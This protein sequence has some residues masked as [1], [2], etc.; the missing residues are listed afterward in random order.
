MEGSQ[1]KITLDESVVKWTWS[2]YAP[3]GVSDMY[4]HLSD[5][6]KI[7]KLA[8]QAPKRSKAVMQIECEASEAIQCRCAKADE[9]KCSSGQRGQ[10]GGG[11]LVYKLKIGV[12]QWSAHLESDRRKRSG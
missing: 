4:V 7:A 12:R 10:R 6:G 8:A 1:Q 9:P 3:S 11:S 2:P 5:H